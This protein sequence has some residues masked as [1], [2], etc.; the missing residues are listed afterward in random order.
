MRKKLIAVLL[1]LCL[2]AS[3][4]A[5]RTDMREQLDKLVEPF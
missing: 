1:I 5:C 2:G 3:L 4:G